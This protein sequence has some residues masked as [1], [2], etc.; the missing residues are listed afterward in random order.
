MP[1]PLRVAV[2]GGG[3][4]GLSAAYYLTRHN[5]NSPQHITL[6]EADGRLGGKIST[7][8]FAD[9]PLDRG[10]DAFLARVPWVTKLCRELGLESELI[11]PA[12]AKRGSGPGDDCAS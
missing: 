8:P 9:M 1:E 12:T 7:E 5:E 3:I 4:A 2:V 6:I 11:A 10:P